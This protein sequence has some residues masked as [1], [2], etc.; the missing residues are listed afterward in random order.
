MASISW[1]SATNGDWSAASDW[2]PASVPDGTSDVTIGASGAGYIVTVT[3]AE[4]AHSVTLSSASATLDL[5]SNL[6]LGGEFA[7]NAGT[8]LLDSG[9]AITGGTIV[10]AGGAL[11]AANGVLDGVTYQGTLDLSPS[12]ALVHVS[13]GIVF[14]GAGGSGPGSINLTGSDATMTVNDTETLNNATLSIGNAGG[15]SALVVNDASG[16]IVT[17]GSKFV[18]QQTGTNAV[19]YANSPDGGSLINQ[20]S[21]NAGLSGGTLTVYYLANFTNQGSIGVSN[22]EQ[23]VMQAGSFVNSGTLSVTNGGAVTLSTDWSNSGEISETDASLNLG[24]SFTTAA[25]STITRSGGTVTLNG[26]VDNSAATLDVGTGSALGTLVLP[27]GAAVSGGVI[28]DAGGGLA[29]QG[30]A[31]DGVTYEGTL[32]LSASNALVHVSGGIVFA[33]AGG[34]GPGSINLT[35]SDATMTVNDTET[36]NNATLSIG[37]A[38]GGSG[39]L[40]NGASGQIV[41]LGS[42]FVV[43]QTG[44][45]ARLYSN[46][47]VGLL[48]NQ[49]SINAGLSGG[50]LTVY[51]LA[52]FTNQ[53]SIGVSNGEQFVM[54]AGSFVNSG[55]LSVTNGGAVTLST[56]W[57]NSGEISETDASLNLG[58]SFTTAALSTITRSGGTVTLNGS[59]D[60]SA[61]T[62]DVGTGSALGTLVLPTGAAVSGGVIHDAGGGLAPQGAALDG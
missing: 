2:N 31:L 41:T 18:V 35:G 49:G 10:A 30:A 62:L 24:G 57:S 46:P 43:Q 7:L 17:L 27:T 13:G 39:L 29:P 53:G 4:A 40:V 1:K 11:V 5:T 59:V 52:N 50:T 55:T 58:G 56:D 36:L 38:G 45:N 34:S 33:G 32:D 9:G 8:L 25:L 44:T 42:K 37:N 19:F 15:G 21:I 20:G 28:H 12:N 3:T 23:F 6:T 51:Y 47:N 14:A 54:Q 22:G 16:Q 60:N 61:A 26:S 48:V